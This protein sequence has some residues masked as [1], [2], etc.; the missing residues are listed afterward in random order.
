MS[1]R[2]QLIDALRSGEYV[3]AKEGLQPVPGEFCALGVGCDLL[4]K[5]GK[6]KWDLKHGMPAFRDREQSL[7]IHYLDGLSLNELGLDHQEA[8]TI[9]N[10]NDDGVGFNEIADWIEART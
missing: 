6:G 3:Q 7:W 5:A 2:Q 1:M 10:M 9:Y 4:V 8:T